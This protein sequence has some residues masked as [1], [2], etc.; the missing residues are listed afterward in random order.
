MRPRHI[1]PCGGGVTPL[2]FKS[3][4]LTACQHC[5]RPSAYLPANLYNASSRCKDA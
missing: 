3:C 4:L 2:Y 5:W 1:D